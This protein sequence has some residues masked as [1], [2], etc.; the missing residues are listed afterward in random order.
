L[1][2]GIGEEVVVVDWPSVAE[3]AFHLEVGLVVAGHHSL[4]PQE[5]EACH[6]VAGPFAAVGEA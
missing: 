4:H 3:A 2:I 1:F 6:Q 5:A